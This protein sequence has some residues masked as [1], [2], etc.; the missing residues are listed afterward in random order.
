MRVTRIRLWA[1][2]LAAACSAAAFVLACGGSASDDGDGDGVHGMGDASIDRARFT[3]PLRP[4]ASCEVVIESPALLESPHVP[5]G[6]AIGWSSNPP[7]SGPHF[8]VWAAF[9]EYDEPVG[10]GYTLHSMEHGAVVLSYKCDGA[11]CAGI[12]D[13]LRKVREAVPTD[14][15]CDP[16]TRVRVIIVPDPALD[17]PVAAAA[18]GFTY[19]AQCVDLP[20]LTDFARTYYRQG[21]ED[22]CAAGRVF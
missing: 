14:P 8:P 4:D 10:R 15:A 19:K 5:E 9:K 17:V 7:S 11:A 20:T 6:T 22:T 3:Q 16:Q 21:P 1:S 13:G 2:S 18:W 12:V